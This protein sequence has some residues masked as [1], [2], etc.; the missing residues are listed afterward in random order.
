MN[1]GTMSSE[2]ALSSQKGVK[3]L[4]EPR[5]SRRVSD[6]QEGA[7]QRG[8]CRPVGKRCRRPDRR[9]S[10]RYAAV[11]DGRE[12]GRV[13]SGCRQVAIFNNMK[14]HSSLGVKRGP[15]QRHSTL[16]DS[17]RLAM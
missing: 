3:H 10:V 6:G 8:G 4:R 11:P 14:C 13:E 17:G 5:V 2:D 9:F 1:M 16:P 15:H 12:R 7:K